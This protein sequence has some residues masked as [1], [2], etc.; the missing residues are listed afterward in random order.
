MEVFA[1]IMGILLAAA[2]LSIVGIIIFALVKALISPFQRKAPPAEADLGPGQPGPQS[3]QAVNLSLPAAPV[4]PAAR[5]LNVNPEPQ[6]SPSPL[7]VRAL[8][9]AMILAGLLL[10]LWMILS[11][12][13]QMTREAIA[14]SPIAGQIGNLVGLILVPGLI[15]ILPGYLVLRR[16]KI[17]LYFCLLFSLYTIGMF[18]YNL[19]LHG[20]KALLNNAL[21]PLRY[22][23]F[24]ISKIFHLIIIPALTGYILIRK[25]KSFQKS[26]SG[27]APLS[28][29]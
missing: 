26:P 18:F 29:G 15:Y 10:M 21:W 4:E 14:R 20:L 16:K 9:T 23:I 22:L 7:S 8:G 25:R 5:T 17:A 24:S 12:T 1:V 3:G 28:R 13:P 27:A 19:N 6:P 2:L 11:P